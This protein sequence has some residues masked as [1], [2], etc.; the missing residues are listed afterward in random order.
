MPPKATIDKIDREI[1]AGL[2]REQDRRNDCLRAIRYY[3]M[4]GADMIPL[5]D[6]ETQADWRARPKRHLPFTN[7]VIKV[8]TSKLYAPGPTRSIEDDPESTEWLESVYSD[9]LINAMWQRADRL[10]HLC[11]M[12]AFQVAGTGDPLNPIK[13][14]VW[15]GRAEIVPYEAPGRANEVAACVLID[16][17]DNQTR[18]TFWTEEWYREYETKKLQTDQTS[19]GRVADFIKQ[20]DNPYGCLP[21]AF[22]WYELPT[23]GV[24]SVHGLGCFLADLNE[25]IDVE[26]SDMAAAVGRYHT[27]LPIAYDC[28]V[29]LQPVVSM[30][31]FVRVNAL[32][33]DL[34]H[35]PTPR[36]RVPPGGARHRGRVDEHPQRDRQRA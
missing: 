6:A 24:D 15:A 16:S 10:S 11:G 26:L 35:A 8:L 22:V 4:E 7:R 27:P 2:P 23:S 5:R 3:K 12:A 20:E 17:V 25:S 31:R 32:P 21:F 19:G 18:Y 1:R 13:I 33:T 9:N 29:A 28:D 36:L 14:Q 30:G 34:D